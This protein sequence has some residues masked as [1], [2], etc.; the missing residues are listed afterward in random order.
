MEKKVSK[1]KKIIIAVIVVIVIAAV[2]VYFLRPKEED[3]M[4]VNQ[5]TPL[6]KTDVIKEVKTSGKIV[7][8]DSHNVTAVTDGKII[9]VNVKEGDVVSKGQTLAVLDSS[10][11]SRE[12]SDAQKTFGQELKQAKVEMDN[13]KSDYQI[14]KFNYDTGDIAKI[15]LDKAR[16]T[17]EAAQTAY[18]N[19]KSSLDLSKFKKQI[20]DCTVTAPSTGTITLRNAEV[21][22]NSSGVMFTIENTQR[23]KIFVKVNEYD[24]NSIKVGQEAVVKTEMTDETE[25]KGRVLRVTPTAIKSEDGKTQTDGKAQFG[26]EIQILNP[27]SKVR[28]GGNARAS[29]ILGGERNVLAVTQ[30]SLSMDKDGND[31]IFTVEKKDGQYYAKAVKVKVGVMNDVYSQISGK[32]LKEGMKV[33]NNAMDV[34]DGQKLNF[35]E[36]QP[37]DSAPEDL[38]S[39]GGGTNQEAVAR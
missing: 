6:E 14:A 23:L 10:S 18:K 33:L 12:M 4:E 24:I 3:N 35:E 9:A 19:K 25:F 37:A 13:A 8:M 15:D 2:A 38:G 21:G 36:P 39:S 16:K 31:I 22:N 34:T 32:E 27:T 1:K 26:V 11:A 17:Y 29:I 20:S 30:D 7:S 5:Y 28:I